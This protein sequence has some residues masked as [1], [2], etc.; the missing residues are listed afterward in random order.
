MYNGGFERGN[1]CLFFFRKVSGYVA[2]ERD[3]FVWVNS[4]GSDTVC[5]SGEQ[6]PAE[7]K[8]R[9]DNQACVDTGP[10]AGAEESKNS[11]KD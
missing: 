5:E 8:R 9:T 7:L 4:Q 1:N 10:C 11:L 2:M 3:G 6:V